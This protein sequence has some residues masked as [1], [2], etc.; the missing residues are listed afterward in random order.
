ME[1]LK[2]NHIV[3]VALVALVALVLIMKSQSTVD[4]QLSDDSQ[5]NTIT[6]SGQSE[7]L[8]APDTASVTFSM[9]RKNNSLSVATDSVNSRISEMIKQLSGFGIEE[10]DIKTTNYSVNPQYVYNRNDGQRTFD[11]YRI[12]QS[13]Q[14]TIR[15]L[16]QVGP[17]MTQIASFEVDNVSGL[18]FF[19]DEDEEIREELRTEAIDDAKQEAKKLARDL[20][21]ELDVIVGFNENNGNNYY[22]PVYARSFAEDAEY[23]VAE[24]SIPTGEDKLQSQVSITYKITK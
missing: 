9:T 21:V 4:V 23:G 18:R 2:Q 17:I 14:L 10:K 1:N 7:R 6:V 12:N 22:G 20:G 16:D 19:V 8:V 11:G 13:L 5:E 3:I 24:A 15:D